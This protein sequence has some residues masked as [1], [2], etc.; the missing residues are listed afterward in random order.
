[1][2][3]AVSLLHSVPPGES[4]PPSPRTCFG[5]D[6]LI[7]QV[8]GLAENLTPIAL[9]GAGGIGKTSVAL[10]VLHH[11]RI[12][13]RFG[14]SRRFIRCDQ[15]PASRAHFLNRLSQVIGAGVK[16]PDSLAPLR[17][18]LSSG[19]MILILDNAESILDPRGTDARAIY[20]AVVEL[21]QF[22][23][24]CL[25]ITS[26]ISIVPQHCKRLVIPTLSMESACDIFY[27][28]YD[29][30]GGSDIISDLLRRLDFHALSIT[31]LATAASH[32]MWDHSRLVREWDV[33]RVQVLR[34][35]YDES[36]AATIELSLASPTFH[37][38]GP[39]ARDLLGVI[40]FFPQ[41]VY[42]NNLNWLFP[43]IPD[44]T[45]IFDK[46]CT[47]SL[48]YRS[49]GF[50]TMLAP[51]R[52]YLRPEDP[53]SSRLLRATK[54]RYF[55]RLSVD[56]HPGKPGFKE[57]QW[58][59]SED[60]NVEHLLDVFTTINANS[61]D[62]WEVCSHF[63]QHLLWHKKRL[64]ILGPK[65]E[66]LPDDHPSK[67]KC[68][69]L[70]SQLFTSIGNEAECKRF[71]VDSL[72][73]WKERADD[74]EVARTLVFLSDANRL[75]DLY[76]EG[77]PQA[78]EALEIYKR[79]N[80]K[81][82]QAL[83]LHRLAALLWEDNQPDTAEGATSRA[84]NLLQDEADQYLLCQCHRLLGSIYSSKGETEKAVD[85][86]ETALRISSLSDW[87]HEQFWGHLDLANLFLID[88]RPDHALAQIELAEPYIH[89]SAYDM[90]RTMELRARVWRAESK[91]GE[92]KSAASQAADIYEKIGAAEDLGRCRAV[93]RTIEEATKNM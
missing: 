49:S 17:P 93:L 26:R 21:S 14:D 66:G 38:L 77:I 91:F 39:T 54:E 62:V 28:I 90:G 32:N 75:L 63:M 12:K 85:Q 80:H 37:E 25:C 10:T 9:I 23:T 7:K 46:F 73:L 79:L 19:E 86:L 48:T 43:T 59:T 50:V 92:A 2:G 87:H 15:F 3:S 67:P 29:N 13:Q 69:R 84:I 47:L 89:A 30:G 70:L 61:H 56:V 27:S 57:A 31:L 65:A 45:N 40:A 41:G 33:R 76:K 18:F 52:E 68:L 11:H 24:I 74:I 5:R 16:N 64:V 4:P 82:G 88:H 34:T 35:D 1:M 83:A 42:E 44:G 60:V 36:L 6:E 53:T 20:A 81:S 78:K 71:L 22:E 8:V 51:L 58:I 55:A 72:R